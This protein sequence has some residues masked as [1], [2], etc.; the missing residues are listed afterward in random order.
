MFSGDD[1]EAEFA[2]E[3]AEDV[4]SELPEIEEPSTL[5]GWG[6]WLLNIRMNAI[7]FGSPVNVWYRD[8]ETAAAGRSDAKIRNV[9]INEK[10]DKKA[11]KY[12][13]S[14]LPFPYTSKEVYESSL[15]QPLGPEYNP[16]SSF[17]NLTR[18]AVLKTTGVVIT[19]AR[20]GK[21][22]ARDAAAGITVDE[23]GVARVEGGMTVLAQKSGKEGTKKQ[24]GS[25]QL[26]R[27]GISGSFSK[28]LTAEKKR[29]RRI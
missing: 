18:P 10:W 25:A 3:K 13:A 7:F 4:A 21:N 27:G 14:S 16:D 29:Q 17:R 9:V 12:T 20:Y 28:S 11:A 1:V 24:Q 23:R 15:R 6:V 2:A 8:R 5:P 26:I 22:T 19:P